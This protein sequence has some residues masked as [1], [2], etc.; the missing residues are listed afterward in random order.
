MVGI[1]VAVIGSKVRLIAALA[2][3]TLIFHSAP[4]AAI[5][6]QKVT[7]PGGIEAWL[8]QEHSIPII[9]VSFAFR[10]GAAL[11]P[12]G[13]EGLAEMVSSLLD[14]GAGKLDSQAFQA[15]LE[16]IAASLRF[17][18][19]RDTF[20]GNL[21]TLTKNRDEAFHLLRLALTS[22]RF[23][24]EPVNRIRA[25]LI[26][27]L[28]SDAE[29]PHSI[30]GRLW[31]KTVF[32]NHPYGRHPDG[33]IASVKKIEITDLKG[34][35]ARQ[36]ARDNL[37][38]GVV[39]NITPDELA[40]RLDEM[41]GGLPDKSSFTELPEAVP[42]STGRTTVVDRD[43]PQSVVVFG[44]QAVKRDDP[45]Y[46]IAYVMNRILGGG[47]FSSRLTTEVREKRGLAYS[48]Y[49]YLNPLDHAGLIMGGVATANSGVAASLKLIRSEWK[50]MAEKGI[51]EKEL[52]SVKT[53]INGSF[54]LRLDSSRRISRI[55]VGIQME[56]LG[57]DYLSRRPSLI[58]AVTAEDVKRIA[59]QILQEDKL[60]VVIVGRPE[61]ITTTP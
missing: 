24:P 11:D 33:T 32:P 34:F 57:I 8:V 15:R 47:G 54:P 56:R 35:V 27:G 16:D 12:K 25:Q 10:G 59:G 22:P 14:E 26:A 30:A 18:A 50:R 1:I 20:G 6:I 48:V 4:V 21:R 28:K 5:E 42:V 13:K 60:T 44:Q 43:I 29:N 36:L 31:Y 61:G 17:R 55:L 49:S 41:F 52:A 39:G 51:D 19:G 53:Y 58:N 38:I 40:V 23:D 46:Y 45:D 3:L 2:A 37:V 9:A 7:S